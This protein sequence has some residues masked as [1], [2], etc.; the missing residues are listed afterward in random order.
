MWTSPSFHYLL[1]TKTTTAA[2]GTSSSQAA[3]LTAKEMWKVLKDKFGKLNSAHIWGLFET[4]ISEPHMSDQRSLQDQMSRIVT[5]IREIS[6]N[7]LQLKEN[8]QALILL[9][10]VPD[11]YGSMISALMATTALD[12]I[13]TRSPSTSSS[14]R[15][16][17]RRL[18]ARPPGSPRPS[19]SRLVLVAIVAV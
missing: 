11:S 2:N 13:L 15:R 18:C 7:G 10:K 8:I 3:T 16:S 9:S 14:R 17:L 12:K 19:P 6:T 5:C 1:E 4:L